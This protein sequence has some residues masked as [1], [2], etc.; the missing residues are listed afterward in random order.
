MFYKK[1]LLLTVV[2]GV[3]LQNTGSAFEK[4]IREEFRQTKEQYQESEKSLSASLLYEQPS[5]D[6]YL[7]QALLYHPGLKAAFYMWQA[8]ME[9]I[10]QAKAVL[11]PMLDYSYR[12]QAAKAGTVGMAE[13]RIGIGQEFQLFGKRG[14]KGKMVWTRATLARLDFMEQRLKVIFEVKEAY[15]DYYWLKRMLSLMENNL[16]LLEQLEEVVRVRYAANASQYTD[17]LR[18]Q[19][20]NGKIK[21]EIS[22]LEAQRIPLDQRLKSLLNIQDTVL[23]PFPVSIPTDTLRWETDSLWVQLQVRNPMLRRTQEELRLARIQLSLT[24]REFL[25]NLMLSVDY[26]FSADGEMMDVLDQRDYPWMG[27]VSLG[28]PLNWRKML[29]MVK[30]M[31]GELQAKFF[32]QQGMQN[33]LKNRLATM[34]FEYNDNRRKI[35]LYEQNL[36]PKVEVEL[37]SMETAFRAGHAD[38]LDL[39]EAQRMR[40]M[41]QQNLEEAVVECAK[42]LAEIKMLMGVE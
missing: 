37:K 19:V 8:A 31:G 13:Q 24:K 12:I 28:L 30:E 25:P 34:I 5:L 1:L 22:S 42:N 17:I 33:E 23:L 7:T 4:K 38:F 15:Y 18:L 26:T 36:I 32:E 27:M 6:R 3:L 2:T 29:G 14:L 35:K 21:N 20:E 41:F 16:K 40:L 39:I 10:P 9:R 11:D